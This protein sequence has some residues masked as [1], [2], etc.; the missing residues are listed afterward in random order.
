[1]TRY[2][3]TCF[4]GECGLCSQCCETYPDKAFSNS[5][6]RAKD[7]KL[8]CG[9]KGVDDISNDYTKKLKVWCS[10]RGYR[11]PIDRGWTKEVVKKYRNNS[12]DPIFFQLI[13]E[14]HP[15][16]ICSDPLCFMIY[17][18][19]NEWN[20]GKTYAIVPLY[21]WK[22]TIKTPEKYVCGVCLDSK[23]TLEI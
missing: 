11:N 8:F 9:R 12:F 20:R 4:S 17:E 18:D 21:S 2:A 7:S 13:T 22:E 14:Y 3:S 5:V 15:S 19:A 6:S 1:M 16:K 10:D 23:N